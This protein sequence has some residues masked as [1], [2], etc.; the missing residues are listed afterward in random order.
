MWSRQTFYSYAQYITIV[1]I[2][3]RLPCCCVVDKD[4]GNG[5]ARDE[6]AEKKETI[7]NCSLKEHYYFWFS[8]NSGEFAIVDENCHDIMILA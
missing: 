1:L 3:S 8:T 5:M 4:P 6:P 7:K 2:I